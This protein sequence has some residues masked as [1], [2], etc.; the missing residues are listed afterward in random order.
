MGTYFNCHAH[1][2]YSNI[3]LLDCINRP[4]SL[5]DKAI[6]MG[7]SGIAITDHECLSA[8]ME[9]NQYAKKLQTTNPNFKIALGNEI[10]L[11]NDREKGQKYYHFI[12]IA[13][14]SIGHKAL[15]ELSSIAWYNSYVDRG[16]ERVPTLKSELTNIIS[17]YKGHVIATTACIGGE[18]SSNA[19]KFAQAEKVNDRNSMQTFYDNIINFLNYCVDLFE[20]DF[21]IE[22]APSTDL[23]QMLVNQKLSQ[24]AKAF[25]IK[26]VVGTD[27]HY[28]TKNERAVHK[29]YLNSKGG[30]REVD[31]FYEFAR[32]M[33]YDEVIALLAPCVGVDFAMEICQNSL[34]LMDKIQFYSLE[35]KQIIPKVEVKDYPVGVERSINAD[36]SKY[37]TLDYL[38][39]SNN[40]Q[41]RYWL[42]ECIHELVNKNLYQYPAYWERLEIEADIIKYIGEQLDD[43]LFAYFNT[44]KHYIDLFWEC[45]SI[46]GPGRGSATGFLSNYLLGITQL[47]PIRWNLPYWRFLN[48]ERAEL[49][50]IDID[51]A[52]SKRPKIFEEIRKERGEFGLIQVATFGTE[53][54]KSAVLTACRGYRGPN[55]GYE[56]LIS[57]D[58]AYWETIQR[59]GIDV[60]E[61]QYM[62]SLI[63]SERG[64]LWPIHD[65]IYGNPEKDRKP[66]TTFIKEVEKYPGLLDIIISIEGLVNKRSSHASGVILYGEDP[67]ETAAF[68]RTPS[69]DLITCYDLHKAEAAGD[70]KYDFLVTEVSDKIIK[71][72]ELLINDEQIE[73]DS[74]R[75]V[76]NKY[77]HPEVID[78]TNTSIWS[79]LA[80][81]DI[82]DVFQFNSGV[83]LAIAKKLKPK[84]PLEMTA[85]NAMMRLM[86][87]KGK[88]S[89]QDRY[90]RIQKNGIEV[91][92]KEMREHHLP[93]EM[94]NLMHKHCDKYYGCCPIQEQMMEILM[95]VAHFTLGEANAARKIVAKKQ[96]DKI[97]DLKKQVYEKVNNPI[98]A[99]YLWEVAVAPQLGYAFSLNH[100][101]PYSFVGIQTIYLA[102]TFNV[103][104]W[105]TACLIVNSGATDEEAGAST[106][107]GKIA[108][109]IGDI[110]AA[111]IKLS[112][113][114]INTSNFGFAPD[115]DNNQILFGLKGL[116]NVG[117]DLIQSIIE[118][119]P[120][121]SP[122]DFLNKV[123]PGKQAMISLIKGGAFDE[124]ED[125]KFVMAWYI[126]ATCDKKKRITLQNMSGLIKYN[127]LPE[128]NEEHI[129]ARRIF[130][131]NRY[132]KAVCK[133]DPNFYTLDERAVDFLN[134][135]GYDHL[136]M[137]GTDV[138]YYLFIKDWDK[139]YQKWMD[140]FRRWISEN[141]DEIL[142]N[143]NAKI[144]KEDWDKYAQGN[145]SSW[146]ME[147]L[148]FYYHEH[149]L[150]NINMSKYGFVDFFKLPEEPIVDR[151]F[152]KAGK[153]INIYKLSKICG[154]CIAKDKTKSTVTIL[155]TTGVVTVK[156]RKE[157]F[158]L[159]DKQ[160]SEKGE[161]GV[162]HIVEKSWFNRGNMIVVMGMR[163]GDD[164]ISKKYAS[165]GGHQLY[166]IKSIN[167]TD[168][169]L[170]D[171]R[172]Q[173]GIE[174][175]V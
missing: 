149:E 2:M 173:G 123:N 11:T 40:I 154:T 6:E 64:F 111:G 42:N 102:I 22:C 138:P 55:S 128:D 135:L 150:A 62:S 69:G 35:R 4:K 52:P 79:H 47:D 9:V 61:A 60:D 129:T 122:K 36:L 17:K 74:L 19:L 155:T 67:F 146:E 10:Y 110:T 141:K 85:A 58:N 97:P 31:S 147:S 126:W 120:Y 99:D 78:T 34:H 132:L 80:A 145:L 68:M 100:S 112:L 21:Y 82:L 137:Q 158:S 1:T 144:F 56:E 98:I 93:E 159:F 95:E 45:G 7:L 14:D 116:L 89:Q 152:T 48:K 106:D 131:F 8:H 153:T 59:E 174:E 148:C 163:S 77:I 88:E 15:R 143:L 33:E 28:L 41:E 26:M 53:G 37:P 73:Q 27:A 29:A 175:D 96:M 43:C 164:F 125:R 3:R 24:I 113:V 172:Y 65:V 92:D 101:L 115:I 109:A 133:K 46:V 107:Y 25:N 49:P 20:D 84:D 168:V 71:C 32:L 23:D 171:K 167:G 156:F 5:I 30:E 39:Y 118:N 54:T 134:E 90:Y 136:I 127:L 130:E 119:R 51:L 94:I 161:D 114:N 124:M 70:T 63:P 81:G 139:V 103:I 91:F 108:K 142:F 170:T 121:V 87:E 86:S 13:K 165:S 12:L 151:T 44:F 75:N 16:M 50:D 72:F 160:I 38:S 166:K 57:I 162:K 76:Y 83:G 157:Y 105:N 140:V 117:D 66:I 169:I 104:Y 18:L